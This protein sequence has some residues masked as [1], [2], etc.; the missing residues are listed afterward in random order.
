MIAD[1][2]F[3]DILVYLTGEKDDDNVDISGVDWA[4]A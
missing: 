4:N 2:Q 1:K 3:D